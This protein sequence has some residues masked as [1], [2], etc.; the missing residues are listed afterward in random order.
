M[1]ILRL[2][3]NTFSSPIFHT[4]KVLPMVWK[5]FKMILS[6]ALCYC[7]WIGISPVFYEWY[8]D[9]ER[10]Q[11]LRELYVF[12]NGRAWVNIPLCLMILYWCVLGIIRLL[13]DEDIR[14]YRTGAI[15]LLLM[16]LNLNYNVVYPCIIG[17]FRRSEEHT[18]E[19]QS[20]R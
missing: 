8:F 4:K 17:E 3:K 13:K 2:Y 15:I 9:S 16:F 19:L 7:A 6:V 14:P 18:S 11:W 5:W 10:T 12:L 20:Q 1:Y